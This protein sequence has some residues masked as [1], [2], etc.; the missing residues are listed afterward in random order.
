MWHS[1]HKTENK[2]TCTR[3]PGEQN[4]FENRGHFRAQNVAKLNNFSF[5][6]LLKR[7]KSI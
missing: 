4:F 2:H 5:F 3:S 7:K 6:F 1:H